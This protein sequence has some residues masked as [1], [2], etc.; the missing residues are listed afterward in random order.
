MS[1]FGV[2]GPEEGF[3]VADVESVEMGGLGFACG[4]QMEEVVNG[5]PADSSRLTVS[6][7]THHFSGAE[8]KKRQAR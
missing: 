4:D 2:T 5:A 7:N 8:I 1:D 6:Q 3:E